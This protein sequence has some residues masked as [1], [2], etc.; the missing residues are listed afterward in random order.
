[1]TLKIDRIHRVH[2]QK[3]NSDP[4]KK[5]ANKDKPIACGTTRKVHVTRATTM[6][7][8][9]KNTCMSVLHVF[10]RKISRSPTK[11]MQANKKQIGHCQKEVQSIDRSQCKFTSRI[12]LS[13]CKYNG[14]SVNSRSWP[15]K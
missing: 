3:F 2:A 14:N 15:E 8:M 10:F 11:R 1:M 5:L 9:V 13:N 6:R 4:R 12:I 7:I